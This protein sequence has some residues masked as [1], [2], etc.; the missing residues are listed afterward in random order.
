[1]SLYTEMN[2]YYE[3]YEQMPLCIY[4]GFQKSQEDTAYNANLKECYLNYIEAYKKSI[5]L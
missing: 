5:T 2:T 4:S 1:M 3:A